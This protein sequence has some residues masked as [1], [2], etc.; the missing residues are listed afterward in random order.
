MSESAESGGAAQRLRAYQ[1]QERRF[2]E[3]RFPLR[4]EPE[5]PAI[6]ELY[7][8]AK[9]LRWNPETDIA[10]SWLDP[11][12][13]PEPVRDSARLV[14]SR[15]AWG[16]YPGLGENTALL[17][18]LCLESGAVGMDAKLFLSFRPAEEAK[19]LETCYLLAERLGGYVPDPGDPAVRRATNHPFAQAALDPDL[20]VEAFVAA[21]GALDDQLDLNLHLSH[22]H[23]AQDEVV[24]QSL[25]LIAA[26]KQ[27]HVLF[28]WSFLA[29]RLPGLDAAGRS[30]VAQAVRELLEQ[31]ILAGYRNT[32]L[33]PGA[34]GEPWVRAEAETAARGLGAST[35][36]EERSVLRATVAQVRERLGAWGVDLPRTSHPELGP[37]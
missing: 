11:D 22:L 15:R 9:G 32:W 29:S 4:F 31:A 25:R 7:S 24:R 5:I 21:L 16:V 26:D 20:P 36:A 18:R 28:A 23:R 12:A 37:V 8:Q 34:S 14:W 3:R 13:Y 10:W 30:A 19:H 33:L 1:E 27:R 6:R 17:V 2:A 35:V